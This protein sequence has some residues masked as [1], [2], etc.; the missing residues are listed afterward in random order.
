MKCSDTLSAFVL[1]LLFSTAAWSQVDS[2][3]DD[4]I[5]EIKTKVEVTFFDYQR[6]MNELADP[7]MLKIYR[8]SV[9]AE[10]DEI[11]TEDA[12]IEVDYDSAYL[13]PQM[14][15]E[16]NVKKYLGDFYTY[17][18]RDNNRNRMNVYY[19]NRRI[20][21]I[22]WNEEEGFYYVIVDFRSIYDGLVPQERV[23]TFKA[24]QVEDQWKTWITYIK[25]KDSP[26]QD[27]KGSVVNAKQDAAGQQQV[28]KQGE[29]GDAPAQGMP[30]AEAKITLNELADGGKKGKAYKI[31]WQLP[32]DNPVSVL[33][34][35]EEGN[36]KPVVTAY[37]TDRLEWTIDKKIKSGKYQIK[38]LDEQMLTSV[39]SAPFRISSRFPL[40]L[41]LAIGAG[42]GFYLVQTARH[43]WN[44]AWPLKT[45]PEEIPEPVR[46]RYDE[47]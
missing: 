33:L 44:V 39:T 17:Y 29:A 18:Q 37:Q 47:N 14:P 26:G 32:E 45:E 36:A 10:S 19:T 3:T 38:V 16:V 25:F 35:P 2:L 1:L 6:I 21:D 4:D 9:I 46:P 43:D 28:Q 30:E 11:F 22:K 12:K 15:Y 34:L 7:K 31:S 41:K 5:I 8:D 42:V 13:P 27:T 23:A 20:S 24:E 40:G